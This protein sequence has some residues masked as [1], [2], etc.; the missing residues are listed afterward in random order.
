M[1]WCKD[2]EAAPM[3]SV[4]F[5][6][7]DVHDVH[8]PFTDLDA[9]IDSADVNGGKVR[10]LKSPSPDSGPR[11]GRGYNRSPLEPAL[12]HWTYARPK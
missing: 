12:K 6:E 11:Q 5:D 8:G 10:P 3:F 7:G 4:V 2:H 9:A 1:Y